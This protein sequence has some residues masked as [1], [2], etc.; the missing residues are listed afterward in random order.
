MIRKY[1]EADAE[2][3]MQIWLNGNVEAHPFVP[4]D[5]WVSNYQMVQEQLSHAEVY[6]LEE[7]GEIRGF[8]GIMD[9][10]IAGIFVAEE[11]RSM[12]IGKQLLE[13]VKERYS[14][15]SLSVYQQNKRA[16]DFYFREGFSVRAEGI[17]EE[18]GNAEYTMSW[19]AT[20]G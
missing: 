14:T 12:G 11:H 19:D 3:V 1:G 16:V 6:V 5:Y 20:A 4:K 13:H 17:D 2:Q 15:L 8:I 10:Y 18:T 9:A 7:D